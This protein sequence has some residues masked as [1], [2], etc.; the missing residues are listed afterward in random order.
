[1]AVLRDYYEARLTGSAAAG[2]GGGAAGGGAG[3]AGAD[4]SSGGLL[5][6]GSGGWDLEALQNLADRLDFARPQAGTLGSVLAA[7]VAAER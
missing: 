1:M 4:A 5:E 6:A 7:L 3:L 2:G